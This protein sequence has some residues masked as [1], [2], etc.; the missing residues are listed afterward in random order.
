MLK[1]VLSN[2]CKTAWEVRLARVVWGAGVVG[3][4]GYKRGGGLMNMQRGGEPAARTRQFGVYW[5]K[6]TCL[7]DAG[8]NFDNGRIESFINLSCFF[9]GVTALMDIIFPAVFSLQFMEAAVRGKRILKSL[10]YSV[11]YRQVTVTTEVYY[12][13]YDFL[14]SFCKAAAVSASCCCL[15]LRPL[16]YIKV[17]PYH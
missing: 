4:E 8:I 3:G 14:L 1:E 16:I 6:G 10:P 15:E 2:L 5:W 13:S 11:F 12:S 7:R 9:Q 17:F